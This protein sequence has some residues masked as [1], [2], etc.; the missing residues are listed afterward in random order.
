[1]IYQSRC[2]KCRGRRTLAKHPNDYLRAP[3]CKSCGGMMVADSYR[4]LIEMP[5][6]KLSKCYCD[7]YPFIHQLGGGACKFDK[8]RNYKDQA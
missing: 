7:G 3:K 5:A 6:K 1:M 2:Q 8:F 4:I